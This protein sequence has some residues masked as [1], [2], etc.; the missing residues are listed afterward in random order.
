MV[1]HRLQE[2]MKIAEK[3]D[4]FIDDPD[5]YPLMRLSEVE[6]CM[7]AMTSDYELSRLRDWYEDA[8]GKA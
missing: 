2:I 5:G 3:L 1:E 8:G 6:K 7:L 4:W